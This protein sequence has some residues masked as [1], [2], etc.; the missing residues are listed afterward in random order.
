MAATDTSP[1]SRSDANYRTGVLLVLLAGVMWSVMGIGIRHIEVANVWQVLFIR[2]AA[3]AV[4]LGCALGIRAGGSPWPAIRA[5]GWAGVIGGFSLVFAF[6]GGIYAIQTTTVANAM[7]LFAAAPFFAAVI[8][9]IVLGERV[10]RA[11]WAAMAVGALGIGIMV[12]NG[13]EAGRLSGNIAAVVAGLGFAVF[14]VALRWGRLGDTIPTVFLAGLFAAIVGGTIWFAN[15]YTTDLPTLD[16]AIAMGLGL[17][18]VGAGL[19]VYTIGS[20]WVP[21][22]EATLLSMTEVVFGPLWV[23]LFLGETASTA[24]LVGGVVLM[25]ALVGNALTGMRRKKPPPVI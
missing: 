8:G 9:R 19:V 11:T 21:A 22:A 7:F 2:S 15:G 16:I 6:S 24:T 17:F 3:L 4:F 20:K 12:W 23:W 5:T 10:R 13:I 14:T 18:Q 25:M 1:V